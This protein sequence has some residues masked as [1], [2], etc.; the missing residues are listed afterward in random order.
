MGN[1]WKQWRAMTRKE[2]LARL[3]EIGFWVFLYLIGV[4]LALRWVSCRVV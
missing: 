3:N 2:R 1:K 4:A